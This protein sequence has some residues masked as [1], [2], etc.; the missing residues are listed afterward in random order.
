MREMVQSYFVALLDRYVERLNDTGLP[1]RSLE[2]LREELNVHVDAMAGCDD[3]SDLCLDAGLLDG[4]QSATR[5][6]KP[7]S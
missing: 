7:A 4:F 6:L 3:L 1:D 5:A 2:A